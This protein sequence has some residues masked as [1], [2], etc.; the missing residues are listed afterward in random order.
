MKTVMKVFQPASEE[1]K[2]RKSAKQEN[3]LKAQ[4]Q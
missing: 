2:Y 4:C 3:H 1:E